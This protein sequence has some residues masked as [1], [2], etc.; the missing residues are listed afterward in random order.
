MAIP[1]AAGAFFCYAVQDAI[2]LQSSAANRTARTAGLKAQALLKDILLPRYHKK[3]RKFWPG[4]RPGLDFAA[5]RSGGMR[6]AGKGIRHE[7]GAP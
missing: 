4:L 6:D 2:A 7:N 3:G 5:P 1:A